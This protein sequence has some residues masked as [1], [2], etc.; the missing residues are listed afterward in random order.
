MTLRKGWPILTGFGHASISPFR[1]SNINSSRS[2]F[3]LTIWNGFFQLSARTEIALSFRRGYNSPALT[4]PQRGLNYA[5]SSHRIPDR[6]PNCIADYGISAAVGR[7]K[8]RDRDRS[9]SRQFHR[10]VIT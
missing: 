9:I 5:P 2:E 1:I 6:P 7:P 4:Q 8:Y 10:L 3:A